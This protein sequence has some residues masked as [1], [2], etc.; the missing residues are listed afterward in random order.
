MFSIIALNS[1]WY[2][3]FAFLWFFW[4][5]FVEYSAQFVWLYNNGV[6]DCI[7]ITFVV[8][9]RQFEFFSFPIF[10]FYTH[11]SIITILLSP[12]Y[13]TQLP[14]SV[15]PRVQLTDFCSFLIRWLVIK[16]AV[17]V[18]KYVFQEFG[19]SSIQKLDSNHMS[20]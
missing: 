10:T 5:L 18:S 14:R 12:Y 16:H 15:W 9:Y 20:Y 8:D 17:K 19:Q 11:F 1:F 6:F 13:L 4:Y 3:L 7:I 2:Y